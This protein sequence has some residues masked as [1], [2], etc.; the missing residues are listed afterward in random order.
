MPS[1]SSQ[2]AEGARRHARIARLDRMADALD[3]RFRVFG[4]PVG[5]DSILGLIPGVGDVVTAGPGVA[6]IYE[7]YRMGARKRSMARMAANTGIDMVLGG[8]PLL[9]DAF[10][11]VFKS[12]RRNMSILKHELARIEARPPTRNRSDTA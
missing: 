7:G 9:G 6:M 10:D 2:D 8:I 5:W 11:L 12:H 1:T 3:A 4:F